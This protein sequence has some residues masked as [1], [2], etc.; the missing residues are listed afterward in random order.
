[1]LASAV[2][3]I[4]S[5]KFPY[6][7]FATTPAQAFGRLRPIHTNDAFYAW[8][9]PALIGLAFYI[10]ARSGGTRLYSTRLAWVCLTLLNLIRNTGYCVKI[11][12]K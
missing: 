12:R 7:D 6:P 11:V 1:V 3:V 5:L 4:L 10:A 8:A 2:S 9:S